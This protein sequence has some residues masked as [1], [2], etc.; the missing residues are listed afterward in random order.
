M[1]ILKSECVE[2]LLLVHEVPS[3]GALIEVLIRKR[4]REGDLSVKCTMGVQMLNSSH[5]CRIRCPLAAL[6]R[7]IEFYLI[8]H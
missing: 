2:M 7:P 3:V 8:E 5:F 4:L 6:L 1:H